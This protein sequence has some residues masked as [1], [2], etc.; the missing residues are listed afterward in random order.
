MQEQYGAN[1]MGAYV[2]PLNKGK[3]NKYECTSFRVI[4]LLNDIG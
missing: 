2:V 4:S 1:R 3:G